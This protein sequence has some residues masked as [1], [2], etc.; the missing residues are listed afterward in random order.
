MINIDLI[1]RLLEAANRR[2]LRVSIATGLFGASLTSRTHYVS[3]AR[4]K[5]EPP[6]SPEPSTQHEPYNSQSPNEA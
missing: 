4:Q 1:D 5:T 2:S 6:L 3:P